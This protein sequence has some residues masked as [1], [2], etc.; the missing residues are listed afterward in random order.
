MRCGLAFSYGMAGYAATQVSDGY[1]CWL[2]GV[3]L[4]EQGFFKKTG[5]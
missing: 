2:P 4:E 3:L 5:P 1:L